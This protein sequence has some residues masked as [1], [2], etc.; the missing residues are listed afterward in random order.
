MKRYNY[1]KT[2]L[3]ALQ[4]DLIDGGA[5]LLFLGVLGLACLI[6]G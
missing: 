2:T 3:T 6:F 5:C 1:R 4:E